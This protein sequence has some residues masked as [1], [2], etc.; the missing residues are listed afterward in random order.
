MDRNRQRDR[1][2]L[3]ISPADY[4]LPAYHWQLEALAF[5]DHLLHCAANGYAAQAR[6]A[7]ALDAVGAALGSFGLIG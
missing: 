2:W 4:A 3:I 6:V 7:A 5:F 1:R